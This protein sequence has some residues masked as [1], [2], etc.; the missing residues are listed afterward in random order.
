MEGSKPIALSRDEMILLAWKAL[1]YGGIAAAVYLVQQ[2]SGMDW[3]AYAVFAAPVT[4]WVVSFLKQF[5]ADTT[6]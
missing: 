6:K 3:G 1:K 2:L 5:A 4:T